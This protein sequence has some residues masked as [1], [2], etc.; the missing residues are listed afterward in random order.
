MKTQQ[1]WLISEDKI[2]QNLKTDIGSDCD[3]VYPTII[4]GEFVSDS[5]SFIEVNVVE[6][7]TTKELKDM[8]DIDLE[9]TEDISN[10]TWSEFSTK[11][12]HFML[13]LLIEN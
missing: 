5:E 1:I 4:L 8:L 3:K 10:E 13:F 9:Y 11:L 6:V 2:Y 7:I 12:W